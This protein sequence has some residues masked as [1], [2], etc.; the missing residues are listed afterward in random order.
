MD[1]HE[2]RAKI[3]RG[4]EVADADLV[5]GSAT[6]SHDETVGARREFTLGLQRLEELEGQLAQWR[7]E[8][9]RRRTRLSNAVLAEVPD[10]DVA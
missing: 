8:V 9:G 6:L 3:K 10:P 2:L 1:A 5:T 7:E 4:D